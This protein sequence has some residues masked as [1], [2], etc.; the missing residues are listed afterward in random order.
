MKNN[1]LSHFHHLLLIA[2]YGITFSFH[3]LPEFHLPQLA[4]WL[5]TSC[6]AIYTLMSL[7]HFHQAVRVKSGG[8]HI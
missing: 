5:G 3:F 2:E 6:Y 1:E 8:G 7:H 4:L